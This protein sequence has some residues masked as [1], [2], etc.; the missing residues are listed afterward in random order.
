M[1]LV[2]CYCIIVGL[3][4]TGMW[5]ASLSGRKVPELYDEPV[6]IGFHLGGEFLTAVALVFS[7]SALLV[8]AP[9]AAEVSLL[10]LGMLLYTTVVSP[11]YFGQKGQWPM[12]GLFALLVAL[13]LASIGWLISVVA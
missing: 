10:S 12:V 6:R 4:M 11:G 5:A 1:T 8:D 2:A 9:W 7:G 13:T 3:G